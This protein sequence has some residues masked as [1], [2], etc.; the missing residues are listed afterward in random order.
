M[1][2]QCRG[3]TADWQDTLTISAFFAQSLA[4]L[5][6]FYETK[7]TGAALEEGRQRQFAEIREQFRA[8]KLHPGRYADFAAGPINNAS[9]LQERI[10]LRD[11]PLFEQLYRGEGNLRATVKLIHAA[12]DKGGDPFERVREALEANTRAIAAVSAR[13]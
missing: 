2:E 4:R 5:Q 3:A 1:S 7:P 12:V 9:L 13:P 6:K 11:L 8:L 10:Y